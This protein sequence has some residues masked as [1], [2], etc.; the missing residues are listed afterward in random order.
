M[1]S[2]LHQSERAVY[3]MTMFT[4]YK[5][6]TEVAA[7]VSAFATVCRNTLP[8]LRTLRRDRRAV[9]ALE[10]GLIASLIAV[11]IISSVNLEGTRLATVFTTIAGKL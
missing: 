7:M 10:Y 3:L 2:P 4:R 5:T 9:T 8:L 6:R 11:T 1:T